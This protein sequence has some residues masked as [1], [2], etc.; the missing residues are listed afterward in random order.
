MT[1]GTWDSASW[2]F[3]HQLARRQVPD[4]RLVS[5]L[6][7]VGRLQPGDPLPVIADVIGE[8]YVNAGS[9]C[10]GLP[11]LGVEQ[12]QGPGVGEVSPPATRRVRLRN[13]LGPPVLGAKAP[14][15]GAPS[16]LT[17]HTRSSPSI[18]WLAK[19]SPSAK[20]SR[21][22]VFD[23]CPA[24]TNSSSSV[25]AS[26]RWTLPCCPETARSWPSGLHS[27]APASARSLSSMSWW[28]FKSHTCTSRDAWDPIANRSPVPS[29]AIT[30]H[31]DSGDV[32]RIDLAPIHR[33][34]E[35]DPLR[36]GHVLGDQQRVA[37]RVE[38]G[39]ARLRLP[40]RS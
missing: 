32:Q 17:S 25:S 5:V 6:W 9:S 8:G 20:N 34:V 22:N 4:T 21:L 14:S 37:V 23:G 3:G 10:Q 40:A 2:E 27:T 38:H 24:S 16:G 36:A 29:I 39:A 19:R 35:P 30:G 12:F 26:S 13:D 33:G 18:P 11:G 28:D 15:S 7:V 31:L 1:D